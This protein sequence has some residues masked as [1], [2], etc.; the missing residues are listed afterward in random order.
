MITLSQNLSNTD[1]WGPLQFQFV[2]FGLG[3]LLGKTL[4]KLS[5]PTPAAGGRA[6]KE[7]LFPAW[8][9]GPTVPT[10]APHENSATNKL[11]RVRTQG[12]SWTSM[13][14][15]SLHILIWNMSRTMP[16]SGL[17]FATA[18]RVCPPCEPRRSFPRARATGGSVQSGRLGLAMARKHQ[19]RV[20][21]HGETALRS[22]DRRPSV[23]KALFLGAEG[24]DGALQEKN[25]RH[26]PRPF[27]GSTV[28]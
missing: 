1:F 16:T 19:R 2:W 5:P 10:P 11:R 18:P 3:S 13:D 20:L 9:P 12:L 4:S 23:E 27:W 25:R 24:S 14:Y 17:D 21:R 8:D 22:R 28:R 6:P 15:P 7:V 26:Q